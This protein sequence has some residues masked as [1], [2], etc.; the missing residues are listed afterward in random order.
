MG[1]YT[2][3]LAGSIDM[4]KT[5]P[6]HE[7]VFKALKD[8]DIQIL[9]PKR[10]DW[11]D[12]WTQEAD[13][14]QFREQVTWEFNAMRSADLILYCF[15]KESKAPVTMYELGRFGDEKDC[16]VCVE[17]GFYRQGNLHLYCE[18]DNIPI[19][20]KLDE[21]LEDLHKALENETHKEK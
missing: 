16:I 8:L 2:I 5:R 12:S 6:W 17:E 10:D 4:G 19:Y 1:K 14:P 9:S 18:F 3:F 13:D 20:R 7:E 11:D 21:M 15:T